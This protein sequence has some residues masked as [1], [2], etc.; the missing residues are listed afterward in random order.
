MTFTYAIEGK[1]NIGPSGYSFASLPIVMFALATSQVYYQ[2]AAMY[3]CDCPS[4]LVK[5]ISGALL[6]LSDVSCKSSLKSPIC[7]VFLLPL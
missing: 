6:F 1:T 2:A 5:S 3:D 4:L 7:N